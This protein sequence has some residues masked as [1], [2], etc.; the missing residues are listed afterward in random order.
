MPLFLSNRFLSIV[1]DGRRQNLR[2]DVQCI[3]LQLRPN[4]T[5]MMI[6]TPG[7]DTPSQWPAKLGILQEYIVA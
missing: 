2:G 3:L 1:E 7:R 5:N 4:R 6:P